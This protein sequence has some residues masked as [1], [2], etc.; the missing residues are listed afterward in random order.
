VAEQHVV[1]V[2]EQHAVAVAEESA[3]AAVGI[4]NQRVVGKKTEVLAKA[5]KEYNPSSGWQK[6]EEEQEESA[7]EQK[8]N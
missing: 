4:I 2:A 8:T 5:L 6:A 3:V 7:A 1:A